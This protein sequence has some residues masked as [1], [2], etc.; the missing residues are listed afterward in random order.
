[1]LENQHQNNF[2][3]MTLTSTE[4]NKANDDN[5]SQRENFHN[6]E[7][8]LDPRRPVDIDTVDEG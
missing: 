7:K 8:V 3:K 5:N 4:L 2:E 6:S 1:M